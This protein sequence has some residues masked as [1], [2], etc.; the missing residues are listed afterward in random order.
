MNHVPYFLK[1]WNVCPSAVVSL[2]K[3]TI[4]IL[5]TDSLVSYGPQWTVLFYT[6]SLINLVLVK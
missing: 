6:N 1:K 4:V 2:F 3:E 5:D